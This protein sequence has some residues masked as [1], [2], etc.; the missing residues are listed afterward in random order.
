MGK[1]ITLIVLSLL[2][3]L[4][5]CEKETEAVKKDLTSSKKITLQEYR[6][7]SGKERMTIFN[8]LEM[9]NRFE[10]LK[11]VLPGQSCGAAPDADFSFGANGNLT[12]RI[13][14]GNFVNKWK[15]DSTGL[16]VYNIKKLERLEHYLGIGESRFNE[17]YWENGELN[18]KLEIET[19]Y[20]TG[21]SL[22]CDAS[23]LQ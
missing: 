20:R 7:L 8:E 1:E 5:S 2:V 19:E 23:Q 15:I 10:L 17:V 12:V 11:A 9:A 18:L 16:T 21:L 22:F 13:P 14:E 6:K 4:S 3:G